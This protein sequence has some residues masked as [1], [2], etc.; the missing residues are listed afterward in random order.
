MS[1]YR[2]RMAHITN[3]YACTMALGAVSDW[4]SGNTATALP[5]Q[6]SKSEADL[7]KI[8]T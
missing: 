8:L 2:S 1:L 6:Q 7:V 5:D 4:G 3:L